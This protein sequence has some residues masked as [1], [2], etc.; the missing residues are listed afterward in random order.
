MEPSLHEV[1]NNDAQIDQAERVDHESKQVGAREQTHEVVE[2]KEGYSNRIHNKHSKLTGLE[3]KETG[4]KRLRT[5]QA[6]S[7]ATK[8][9]DANIEP[10]LR[11]DTGVGADHKVENR[12]SDHEYVDQ[13]VHC[14]VEEEFG[15]AREPSVRRL[16]GE[17]GES[18]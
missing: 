6:Y 2:N 11:P 7:T 8:R 15:I 18:A 4:E 12:G 10:W 9:D 16:E 5:S 13:L 17:E 14:G 3:E 1:G